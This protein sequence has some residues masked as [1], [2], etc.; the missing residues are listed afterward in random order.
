LVTLVLGLWAG[1]DVKTMKDYVLAN[2]ELSTAVVTMSL[3][4]TFIGAGNLR[5]PNHIFHFGII[6]MIVPAF[7]TIVFFMVGIFVAPNLI[8]FQDCLTTGDLMKRFYGEKVRVLTGIISF[9][10]SVLIISSQIRALVH[11]NKHLLK[12][13]SEVIIGITVLIVLYTS[14]SGMRGIAYTDVIQFFCMLAVFILFAWL[15]IYKIGGLQVL[16][17]QL[18]PEKLAISNHPTFRRRIGEGIAYGIFA[19]YL[20]SPALVHRM[21][22]Q[23]DKRRVKNMFLAS[24]FIFATLRVIL[25][26]LGFAAVVYFNNIASAELKL[27]A[28][29]SKNMFAYLGSTLF[30]DNELIQ[31]LVFAALLFVL[32][33]TIDSYLHAA[34]IALVH[35]IFKPFFDR[36]KSVM[37]EVKW[38][39]WVTFLIGVISI[40][41][42]FAAKDLLTTILGY[43]HAMLLLSAIVIPLVI[44]ILGIKT[45]TI[46]FLVFCILFGLMW[47]TLT[48]FTTLDRYVVYSISI[49]TATLAFFI[50]HYMQNQGFVTVNRARRTTGYSL[51]KPSWRGLVSHLASWVATPAELAKFAKRKVYS[52]GSEPF[53]FSIFFVG[54]PPFIL[55]SIVQSLSALY[56]GIVAY[57]IGI[58]LVIGLMLEVKWFTWLRS[59]FDLYWFVTLG[60]CL[61]FFWTLIF[62]INPQSTEA[63]VGFCLSLL[64]L[65]ICVDWQTFLVLSSLGVPSAL[66]TYRV[67]SG[68]FWPFMN[69]SMV[70]S[71]LTTL[72]AVLI[73]GFFFSRKKELYNLSQVK[74]AKLYAGSIAHETNNYLN[75]SMF[76]GDMI[77]RAI[78][79]QKIEPLAERQ[80]TYTIPKELAEI[81]INIGPQLSD[82]ARQSTAKIEMFMSALKENILSVKQEVTS[83]K[84]CIEEALQDIYFQDVEVKKGILLEIDDDFKAK[85]AKLYFKHIVYNLVKN[86]Y[87][88]GGASEIKIML[89][90]PGRKLIV[91]DN[92]QGISSEKLPYIFDLFYSG[93]VSSGIGLAL[94]KLI[95]ESFGA[96]L[97]MSSQQ[98]EAAFT[99]VSIVF[100][101]K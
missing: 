38:A 64:V 2:R 15:L 55:F 26:L 68:H 96:T 17:Q 80:N 81:L 44:G 84:A 83:V 86:A 89:D 51:L 6:S 62:L 19:V 21:L 29:Q 98:G 59:Y 75:V 52:Y 97:H 76:A 77:K 92:G 22:M 47:F 12:L 66:I 94:V 7:Y 82:G 43:Y 54:I 57:S 78:S 100:P 31:V 70:Y 18:P 46:S 87:H 73:T 34:G 24:G 13:P 95:V 14:L 49:S 5:A 61:P 58:T 67:L 74:K 32:A 53:L 1:K 33:S 16:L 25:M 71:L 8:Y 23:Q 4:A 65:M 99:E 85:L 50:S 37:N 9:A 45:D 35:D 88:H 40:L 28:V 93:G 63:M 79:T 42:G 30:A 11:I 36:K 101:E 60:Y 41:V 27:G 56:V 90:K 48:Y 20:F 39:R 3:V 10:F 72:S 69:F 91:R